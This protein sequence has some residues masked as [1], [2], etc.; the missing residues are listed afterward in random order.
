MYHQ[1]HHSVVFGHSSETTSNGFDI[2]VWIPRKVIRIW[3]GNK[4]NLLVQDHC[5][6]SWYIECQPPEG[7]AGPA[8]L[9]VGLYPTGSQ[10]GSYAMLKN[11][12]VGK[13]QRTWSTEVSSLASGKYVSVFKYKVELLPF[14]SGDDVW[15]AEEEATD[16][17]S[18][19]GAT[20]TP[21]VIL[22]EGTRQ[23]IEGRNELVVTT[24]P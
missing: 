1:Y 17:Y 10:A 15:S 6:V 24:V 8:A 19:Q 20:M 18:P 11:N 21:E 16:L 5:Q 14:K 13:A 7:I 3:N 23:H 4:R 22:N 12:D 2:T 9:L